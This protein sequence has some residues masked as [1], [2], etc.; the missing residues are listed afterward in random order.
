M[1]TKK[2]NLLHTVNN[3][4]F[5]KKEPVSIVHF[6]TNRCNARCSFCFIDFD[7]PNNFKGELTL[8]EIDKLK[9]L[10]YDKYNNKNIS[11]NLS[12]EILINGRKNLIQRCLNNLIDNSIKYSNNIEI[13]L[14]KTTN[15][16]TITIDDDGPGIA[17]SEYHNITK[18]FYKMFS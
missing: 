6:L 15:N 13:S 11:T 5:S 9:H 16:L 12:S 2:A 1:I 7:N 17:E 8:N 3:I 14:K 4:Y 10:V 18:Q